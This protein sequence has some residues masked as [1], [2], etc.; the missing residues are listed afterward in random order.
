MARGLVRISDKDRTKRA[1]ASC[2][3]GQE[4]VRRALVV[5]L[6]EFGK[7]VGGAK[8]KESG[9]EHHSHRDAACAR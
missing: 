6:L 4:E 7:D 1:C 5:G 2:P 9:Q 3:R 8:G